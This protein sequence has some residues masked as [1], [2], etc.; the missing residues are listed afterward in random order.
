L[1]LPSFEL[2]RTNNA[3][4]SATTRLG[5]LKEACCRRRHQQEGKSPVTGVDASK[6][7][8]DGSENNERLDDHGVSSKPKRCPP[9]VLRRDLCQITRIDHEMMW[10]IIMD[11]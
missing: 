4:V 8:P 9:S 7:V 10:S 1:N 3:S 11:A 5:E 6:R 2:T